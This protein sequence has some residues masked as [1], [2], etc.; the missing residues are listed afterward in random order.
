MWGEISRDSS[1]EVL[2]FSEVPMAKVGQRSPTTKMCLGL[3]GFRGP[4]PEPPGVLLSAG[5][6]ETGEVHLAQA[7]QEAR[8]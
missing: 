1:M 6:D 7:W 3:M 2:L 4:P 8:L 5:Q